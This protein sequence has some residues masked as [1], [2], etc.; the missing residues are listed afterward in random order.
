MRL[1]SHQP[2]DPVYYIED[3]RILNVGNLTT[4]LYLFPVLL[5]SPSAELELEQTSLLV[6]EPARKTS[7]TLETSLVCLLLHLYNGLK[8]FLR[9]QT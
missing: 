2:S 9:D 8:H 1:L 7:Q 4:Q 3:C 5:T 6:L